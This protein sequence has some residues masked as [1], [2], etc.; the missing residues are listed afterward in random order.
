MEDEEDSSVDVEKDQKERN[1]IV[2]ESARKDRRRYIHICAS[3]SA[4]GM[5]HNI[6][7]SCFICPPASVLKTL[8]CT[9]STHEQP[10]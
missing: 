4:I 5:R 3:F 7:W 1:M 9:L 8:M 10:N 2:S 6:V